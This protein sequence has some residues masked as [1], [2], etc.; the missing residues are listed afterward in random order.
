ML[1]AAVMHAGSRCLVASSPCCSRAH[2]N[3]FA[4]R[5]RA[6]TPAPAVACELVRGCQPSDRSDL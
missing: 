3:D 2:C 5:V 4:T 1:I 6:W